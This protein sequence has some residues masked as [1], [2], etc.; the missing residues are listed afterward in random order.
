[1]DDLPLLGNVMDAATQAGSNSVNSIRFEIK[2]DQSA[3]NEGIRLATAR[4]KASAIGIALAL[5]VRVL[6]VVSAVVSG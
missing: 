1:V 3:R 4:A 2:D 5:G 6:G